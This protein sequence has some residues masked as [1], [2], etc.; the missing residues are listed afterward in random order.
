MADFSLSDVHAEALKRLA[1]EAGVTVDQLLGEW[2]AR[3]DAPV[4][5]APSRAER[6]QCLRE[7]E[8]KYDMGDED[9]S[10]KSGQIMREIFAAK[11]D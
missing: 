5:A 2:I 7:L 11:R 8:G 10:L 6:E 4:S 3:Y 1:D 9:L